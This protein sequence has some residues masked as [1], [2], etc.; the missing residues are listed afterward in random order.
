M[1]C[2]IMNTELLLAECV[3]AGIHIRVVGDKLKLKAPAEPPQ[4]ML[5]RLKAAKPDIMAYLE[6]REQSGRMAGLC[7]VC[8]RADDGELS[9]VILLA[10]P[11]RPWWHASCY[12]AWTSE[13]G[14]EN[15]H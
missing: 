5:A 12:S 14:V 4:E 6:E 10:Q 2:G 3:G 7:T 9:L 1:G 11:G 8:R 13:S 15:H